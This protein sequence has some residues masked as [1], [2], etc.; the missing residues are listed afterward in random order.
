MPPYVH[1]RL[2]IHIHVHVRVHTEIADAYIV[3]IV[4]RAYPHVDQLSEFE[5]ALYFTIITMTTVGYGDISPDTR[6]GRVA[7]VLV[8]FQG[9]VFFALIIN[10]I[11]LTFIDR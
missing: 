11:Y 2:Q 3:V 10:G 1:L 9:M 6:L 4:E 7:A 5:N 8:A